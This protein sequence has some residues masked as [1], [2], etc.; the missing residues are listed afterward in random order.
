[1]TL[2]LFDAIN[3]EVLSNLV[4]ATIENFIC[5][6]TSVIKRSC[7][8]LLFQGVLLAHRASIFAYDE[9][10]IKLLDLMGNETSWRIRK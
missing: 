1:M 7:G 2:G 9:S 3:I 6:V 5:D 8:Y 10:Y 4:L